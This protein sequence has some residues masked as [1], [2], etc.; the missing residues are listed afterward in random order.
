[1][2]DSKDLR[3][4]RLDWRD[5]VAV[6]TLNRPDVLNAM[7]AELIEDIGLALDQLHL[8]RG[9]VRALVL[10]GA[11]KAFCAGGD[12][13]AHIN[14]P[15]GTPPYDLADAMRTLFNPL[16]LRLLDL[17]FPFVTA[18]NG[19][20]AGAGLP[21]SLFGDVV[22]ASRSAHFSSGFSQ[23]ALLPDMGLTWLLPRLIGRARAHKIL[24]LGERVTGEQGEEW[25]MIDRCV[26]D[27][28]LLDEAFAIA[29]RL[30][31]ASITAL[32]VTRKATLQAM[33][34]GLSESLDRE[35]E[36]QRNL[37]FAGDFAE[38]I[39]A[40]FEKRSPKFKDI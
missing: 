36:Y 23:I 32:T 35:A 26:A 33:G 37:G 39:T 16:L 30:A 11:G 29:E 15:T 6:L 21:L 14:K 24:L 18:V 28:D 19:A 25:G 3:H 27:D 38:G 22:V 13:S 2:G 20:A 17:P 7:S 9:E 40:F 12:I 31:K 5:D 4:V 1:M 10:T 34:S 8:M